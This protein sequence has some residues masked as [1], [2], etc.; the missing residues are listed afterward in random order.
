VTGGASTPSAE[1]V[2]LLA[3]TLGLDILAALAIRR[4]IR[5]RAEA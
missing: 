3:W 5:G 4:I 2:N 1:L